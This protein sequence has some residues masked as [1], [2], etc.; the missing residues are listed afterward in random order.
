MQGVDQENQSHP[1]LFLQEVIMELSK[2]ILNRV[3]IT[4]GDMNKLIAEVR[5]EYTRWKFHVALAKVTNR[6]PLA[7]PELA[8]LRAYLGSYFGMRGGRAA[9]VSRR[10]RMSVQIQPILKT[11][12]CIWVGLGCK[13]CSDPSCTQRTEESS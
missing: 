1:V 9:A 13:E 8:E 5:D 11:E 12:P 6:L 2:V 10:K 7:K 3:E 4:F